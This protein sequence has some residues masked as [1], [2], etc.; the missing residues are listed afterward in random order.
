MSDYPLIVSVGITEA[1]IMRGVNERI[2]GYCLA[3]VLVSGLV[4][5]FIV[6]LLAG[7]GRQI[8]D[9]KMLKQ[10][11]DDLEIKVEQRTQELYSANMELTA[12]NS[13][14]IAI[15]ETLEMFNRELKAEI[16]ERE[17][18]EEALR[19]QAG[20]I[21]RMAYFD[22]LTG[23]PNR[24]H[25][26]ERLSDELQ[27]SRSGDAQ[28]VVLFIDLDD[29]KTVNDT[30]G[31]TTGDE[32]ITMAGNRIAAEAG[33]GAFVARIGGDEFIVIIPDEGDRARVSSIADGMIKA[34]GRVHET[35]G[36]N[37]HM[38]ASI[39]IAVYPADGETAEEIL[40]NAD[41]A[42]YAAKRDGKNCWRF[43]EA[44]MQ[45]E[46]YDRMLLINS[47]RYAIER[48]ELLLHY[49]PQVLVDS[50]AVVGF[51]ALVR[52]MSPELGSV[53]PS[54]FIPLAEESGLIQSIGEWVLREACRFAR[55]LAELGQ[56]DIHVAVN[57]SPY[58][59]SSGDFVGTVRATL[60]EFGVEPGQLMLEITESVLMVSL[61]DVTPKFAELRAAGV[62]LSL[63]DFGVGYSSLTYLR[64]LPVSTLKIDK[65]F[66]EMI[67]TDVSVAEIIGSIIDLAH[68]L[69]MSVVAEGVE[70]EQQLTYL[71]AK[72][73]DCIQGYIFSQPLPESEAV[74]YLAKR[75]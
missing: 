39:G 50:R 58:Q 72:G 70:T 7:A 9:A 73:C 2:V 29:L 4:I 68:I 53:P 26:N 56:G 3:A 41:N 37:F 44:A 60:A 64:Y 51:E 32:I 11:R 49:Q 75:G 27:R 47:L 20:V 61:E 25:L 31:H 59:L 74:E 33:G 1:E 40:K 5:C 21:R 46:A 10:A 36:T 48:G 14:Y 6:I 55:R 71:A 13:N 65:S 18:G 17:R 35:V 62:R 57:V 69:K 16:A 52:W 15:N 43:Y 54:R 19:Q 8:R 42:L 38:S 34:L 67:S 30:F 66:V 24:A 22:A 12:V 63:D 23:L 45:T 28:G